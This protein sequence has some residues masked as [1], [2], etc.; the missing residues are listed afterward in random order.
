MIGSGMGAVFL[1]LR[2]SR[3][4][5]TGANFLGNLGVLRFTSDNER[6]KDLSQVRRSAVLLYLET[7]LPAFSTPHGVHFIFFLPFTP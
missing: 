4:S 7:L 6:K 1:G 3:G 2:G 5:R